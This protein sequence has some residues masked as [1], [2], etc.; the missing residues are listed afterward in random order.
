MRERQVAAG[1]LWQNVQPFSEKLMYKFKEEVKKSLPE[2]RN[3]AE[4]LL[5]QHTFS[6][7]PVASSQIELSKAVEFQSKLSTARL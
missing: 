3:S 7:M 6:I 4:N 2:K 1:K 5:I